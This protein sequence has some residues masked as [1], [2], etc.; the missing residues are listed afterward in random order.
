MNIEEGCGLARAFR[1][2]RAV[3][4]AIREQVTM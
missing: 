1:G 4:Y 2:R 3:W